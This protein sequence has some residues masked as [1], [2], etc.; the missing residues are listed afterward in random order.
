MTDLTIKQRKW[1]RVYI[2][3][4]NATEAAMQVYDCKDR[5]VAKSIG[6]ENLS[7][8]DYT[9][10]ME[11]AGITD[12]LLQ[13][14]IMEG[15]DATRTVSAVNTNKNATADS[16]D[17]IDVPDFMARHKYLET[18]LKLKKRMGTE[19][20][21]NVYVDKVIAILGGISVSESHSNGEAP[22]VKKED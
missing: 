19:L 8:L 17:F 11:E 10:F 7:K 3:T 1:I 2:D 16:T 21:G 5:D 6:S 15:L 9:D 13:Q 18:A 20:Q 14:K 12:K 4:G 22:E